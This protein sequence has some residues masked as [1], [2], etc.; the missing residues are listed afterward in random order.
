MNS[1]QDPL[2][3]KKSKPLNQ[4]TPW[5]VVQA[6]HKRYGSELHVFNQIIICFVFIPKESWAFRQSKPFLFFQL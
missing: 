5:N 6:F 3:V 2:E 1:Q 4:N